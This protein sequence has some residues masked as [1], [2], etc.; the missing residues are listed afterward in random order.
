M[1]IRRIGYLACVIIGMSM[2][3]LPAAAVEPKDLGVSPATQ[4]VAAGHAVTPE[5]LFKAVSPSVVR[6]ISIDKKGQPIGQGSGFVAND[7]GLI[8]TNYHVVKGASSLSVLLDGGKALEVL[9]VASVDPEGDLALVKVRGALPPPLKLAGVLPSV[10]ARTYAIGSPLGLT[11]TLSEGLVSGLRKE[12]GSS[13]GPLLNE[14]KEVLGVTTLCFIVGQNLNF[15]V[16]GSRIRRLIENYSGGLTKPNEQTWLPTRFER[17][18]ASTWL[19][20]ASKDAALV[21][22]GSERIWKEIA[23]QFAITGDRENCLRALEAWRSS[24][25]NGNS[26]YQEAEAAAVMAELGDSEAAL[27]VLD[28]SKNIRTRVYGYVFVANALH[29]AGDLKGFERCM[30]TALKV[31][32]PHSDP[33]IRTDTLA[34]V[35]KAYAD[36]NHFDEAKEVCALLSDTADANLDAKGAPTGFRRNGKSVA[37][38]HIALALA[39]SGDFHA[40]YLVANEMFDLTDQAFAMQAV[41]ERIAEAGKYELANSICKRIKPAD[42]RA[43]GHLT[44]AKA[45]IAKDDRAGG[46][47]EI[48]EALEAAKSITDVRRRGLF[49]VMLTA[50]L[51]DGGE[52]DSAQ[53]I[54][55]K[56]GDRERSSAI[57]R[58]AV[59]QAKRGDYGQAMQSLRALRNQMDAIGAYNEIAVF[60]AENGHFQAACD[61]GIR[62]TFGPARVEALR[63]IVKSAARKER[64]EAMGAA[65]AKFRTAEERAYGYLGL[66]EGIIGKAEG[67]V[68]DVR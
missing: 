65:I 6:I 5:E 4:P 61:T 28:A 49:D 20:R 54:A 43:L 58:I 14:S 64:P 8:V 19:A 18:S 55:S 59:A 29:T 32:R 62:I 41:V 56:T 36:A 47:D 40:A 22:V 35:V 12:T 23:H 53:R 48:H 24:I 1:T 39:K 44:I 66:A 26:W 13:G 51:A 67:N 52:F 63:A 46:R 45:R 10:G 21:R 3:V 11:N 50:V 16:E 68:A 15:A 27:S 42:Y 31:A 7:E 2:K 25:G 60:Q 30:A 57:A 34:L 38:G 33:I 17:T 37:Q 9:G